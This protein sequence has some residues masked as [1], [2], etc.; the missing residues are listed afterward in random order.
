MVVAAKSRW[1]QPQNVAVADSTSGELL[2]KLND[3]LLGEEKVLE[4][5]SG[6]PNDVRA[7]KSAK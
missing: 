1:E 3:A 7:E 2:L 6:P 4:K 5:K